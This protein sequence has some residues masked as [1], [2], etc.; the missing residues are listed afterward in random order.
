MNKQKLQLWKT[1]WTTKTTKQIQPLILAHINKIKIQLQNVQLFEKYLL[2]KI[3][4]VKS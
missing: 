3:S 4:H 1:E 2:C